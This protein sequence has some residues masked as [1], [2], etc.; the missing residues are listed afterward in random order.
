MHLILAKSDYSRYL[1]TN[2]RSDANA[3]KGGIARPTFDM[4]AAFRDGSAWG[5]G[6]YNSVG[7]NLALILLHD[8]EP[9]TYLVRMSTGVA[10][11]PKV[12][13]PSIVEGMRRGGGDPL[14]GSKLPFDQT[15]WED[16]RPDVRRFA[17][18]AVAEESGCDARPSDIRIVAVGYDVRH[19]W[20][21]SLVGYVEVSG[22]KPALEHAVRTVAEGAFE[23]GAMEWRPFTPEA[24]AEF[25][26]GARGQ[27]SP[28]AEIT[29]YRAVQ[30]Y[31][32]S[33]GWSD[34][35]VGKAF[36]ER[37]LYGRVT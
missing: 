27:L 14:T 34:Y 29:L 32:R 24:I 36:A 25:V 33:R 12:W 22:N 28:W 20:Q 23:V 1:A 30:A 7:M 16:P 19:R 17:A 10:Q 35:D 21:P 26:A 18:R 8:G 37:S 11:S 4:D 2:G 6:L 31:W 5:L 3:Q 13:V 15:S 9:W